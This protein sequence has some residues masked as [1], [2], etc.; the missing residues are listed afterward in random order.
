MSTWPR[1]IRKNPCL[2]SRLGSQAPT[3][4]PESTNLLDP[5]RPVADELRSRISSKRRF[6]L[7]PVRP[8]KER[9]SESA[10]SGSPPR[11]A[12]HYHDLEIA[13]LLPSAARSI[14]AN[15]VQP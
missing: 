9:K 15:D 1:H 4:R 8:R 13:E 2:L 12:T 14:R 5:L 6:R 11:R 3:Q 7:A 10:F